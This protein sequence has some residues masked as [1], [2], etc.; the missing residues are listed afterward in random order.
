MNTMEDRK[1]EAARTMLALVRAALNDDEEGMQALVADAS[2]RELRAVALVF[3][4]ALLDMIVRLSIA[5][6]VLG[7]D[8]GVFL[9]DGTGVDAVLADPAARAA[10]EQNIAATQARLIGG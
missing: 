7:E 1:D 8:E 10:V 2:E 4:G 6:S 5:H 3:A 9:R